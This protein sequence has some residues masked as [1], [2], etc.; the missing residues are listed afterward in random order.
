MSE[1]PKDRREEQ[2]EDL[3]EQIITQG[4]DKLNAPA[5]AAGTDDPPEAAPSAPKAENGAE[6]AHT[7]DR[8]AKR[9]A[10][11]FCLML[12]FGAAF[13]MLLP[14]YFVQRRSSE[15][16]ISELRDSMNLSREELAAENDE[17]QQGLEVLEKQLQE[18]QT[19]KARLEKQLADAKQAADDWEAMYD[20]R[21]NDMQKEVNRADAL[22][23]LWITDYLYRTG[24]YRDC[25]ESLANFNEEKMTILPS[26]SLDRA[27]EICQGLTDRGLLNGELVSLLEH[28]IAGQDTSREEMNAL[29][30]TER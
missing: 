1:Q 19:Q 5:Q 26:E 4:L 17:L 27:L 11:Y 9:T 2:P 18:L 13:L 15:A 3:L 12:L 7:A 6:T 10:V 29:L 16:A 28:Y 25:A 24:Q 20:S 21:T 14:A 8:K 23:N 30:E 22:V